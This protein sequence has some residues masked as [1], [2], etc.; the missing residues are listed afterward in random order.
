MT[1]R[2]AAALAGGILAIAPDSRPTGQ[3]LIRRRRIVVGITLVLGATLLGFSLGVDP[4]N[5]A[6]Y[7][8][9]V[10]TAL[11]WMIGGVLSGP[12]RLG[13]VRGW[14]S[15]ALPILLGLAAAGVFVLGALV[16]REIGPLAHQVQGVL[17]FTRQGKLPIV[18]AVTAVSGVGEEVFF[19][20]ALFSAAQKFHPVAVSA[21]LYTLSTIATLNIM[22]VFAAA[23][24]SIVWGLQ[25]RASGGVLAPILTH[26]TWSLTMALVLPPLF[27]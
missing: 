16:V 20:G 17:A 11:V 7:P 2:L 5:D 14:R 19:R 9:A 24:L 1:S 23:L 8:L 25:R 10:G 27:A 22:L 3:H 26:V 15:A 6:F 21:A 4:G 13:Q 18:L 12:L